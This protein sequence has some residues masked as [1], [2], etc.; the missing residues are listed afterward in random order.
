[1]CSL[2]VVVRQ[3]PVDDV[4]RRSGLA[5]VARTVDETPQLLAAVTTA[6]TT[7]T[8]TTTTATTTTSTTA[9]TTT[10]TN[11]RGS[12][13]LYEFGSSGRPGRRNLYRAVGGCCFR[14]R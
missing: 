13:A 4:S 5:A 8:A 11:S 2:G 12:G 1:M 10:T 7:T 3:Q 6:A 14:F 9:T